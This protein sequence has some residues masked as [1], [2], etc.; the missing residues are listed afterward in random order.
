MSQ[1]NIKKNP[2]DKP[3][4]NPVLKDS[5]L[6]KLWRGRIAQANKPKDQK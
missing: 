3:L 4:Q 1:D 2:K 5:D 6:Q